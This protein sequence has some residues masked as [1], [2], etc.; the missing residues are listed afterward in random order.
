[1]PKC[2]GCI[3]VQ[4][5]ERERDVEIKTVRF[6]SVLF[7]CCFLFRCFLYLVFYLLVYVTCRRWWSSRML[8]NRYQIF[9]ENKV[10]N[11]NNMLF[12]MLYPL[13]NTLEPFCALIFSIEL[14]WPTESGASES[15]K[16]LG[17]MCSC[18]DRP[19]DHHLHPKW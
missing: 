2:F 5:K 19:Y 8:I 18:T 13:S 11:A 7:K 6:L 12:W 15:L 16:G 4:A 14:T 1:M 3:L 9:F 17:V 10:R